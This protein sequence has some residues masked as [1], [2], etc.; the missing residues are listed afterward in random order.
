MIELEETSRIK[1]QQLVVDRLGGNNQATYLAPFEHFDFRV[2]FGIISHKDAAGLSDNLPL[3]SKI[4]LMRN[5]QRLD[6][7][8]V[9]CALA[10][11]LG[12]LQRACVVL[13]AVRQKASSGRSLKQQ[14]SKRASSLSGH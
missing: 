5:M 13:I 1:M 14:S 6:V 2:V 12:L 7:M 11:Q 9:P 3:F 8:R 4:S 10:W